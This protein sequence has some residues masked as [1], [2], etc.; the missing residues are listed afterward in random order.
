M[1]GIGGGEFELRGIG[2]RE[3]ELRGIGGRDAGEP[4]PAPTGMADIFPAG[5]DGFF[6]S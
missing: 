4:Q 6:P 5:C 3:A 2:G 1:R